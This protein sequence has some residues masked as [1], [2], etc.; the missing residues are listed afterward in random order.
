[1]I[2]ATV[3]DKVAKKVEELLEERFGDEDGLAFEQVIV[4]PKVDH[5]GDEYLHIYVV[6]DGDQ[7]LLDPDWTVRLYTLITPYLLE[8]GVLSPPSKSFVEKS[9]WEEVYADRYGKSA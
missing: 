8:L 4:I 3:R 9:D 1:M 6:F 7:K 5:D 2:E